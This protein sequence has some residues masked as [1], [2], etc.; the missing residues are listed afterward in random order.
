[1][2]QILNA[3]SQTYNLA[4]LNRDAKY[5]HVAQKW[6]S[7]PQTFR[8][9]VHGTYVIFFL[10]NRN[11]KLS[12]SS[13]SGFDR[14]ITPATIRLPLPSTLSVSLSALYNIICL[15]QSSHP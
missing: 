5:P 4:D 11:I 1:M 15:P 7:L 3:K 2:R 12:L 8:F 10:I 14:V 13:F 9:K 6:L